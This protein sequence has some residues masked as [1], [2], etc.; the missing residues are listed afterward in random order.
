MHSQ[1][2]TFSKRTYHLIRFIMSLFVA[3]LYVLIIVSASVQAQ[4]D[5]PP[6][7]LQINEDGVEFTGN[8]LTR[9]LA[10]GDVDNDGDLDLAVANYQ[11]P[12]RVYFNEGGT[13]IDAFT[14]SSNDAD[15]TTS[16]AWGDVDNDGDLDLAVGNDGTTNKIYLNIDGQ[17]EVDSFW[18]TADADSTTSIVWGDIDG[19]DNLDLVSGNNG[20]V[21]RA[22]F[23]TG[24][25]LDSIAAWVSSEANSTS[26][27]SLGDID[28]D[29]NLDLAVGNLGSP[30][31]VY[32]GN[33]SSLESTP[34]WS[35]SESNWTSSIALG[36]MDNNG[37]LDFVAGNYDG[38][39][40]QTEEES[41][42]VYLNYSGQPETLSSWTTLSPAIG[43]VTTIA[44]GDADGDGDLDLA[45]ASDVRITQNSTELII[46][47]ND[48]E[49]L[50]FFEPNQGV[51]VHWASQV[52]W[53]DFDNDGD[54]DLAVVNAELP[55]LIF[56]NNGSQ[57]QTMSSW[58]SFDAFNPP[59]G[60]DNSVDTSIAWGDVDNDGDL[61]L[62][63]SRSGN[64]SDL[65]ASN[66]VYLNENGLLEQSP[67]WESDEMDHTSS[68]AWGDVDGDGDLDLAVGNYEDPNVGPS[69]NNRV[70]LNQG[71]QLETTASWSSQEQNNTNSIAWGDVDSDGDLD[72][73]VGNTSFNGAIT[74]NAVNKLYLNSGTQL[75]ATASWSSKEM[76][77]TNS[78]S[79]GDV[80]GDGD[81][82]LAVGNG[83]FELG[84]PFLTSENS[85][86]RLYINHRGELQTS[87]KW[88]T[89]EATD[90]TSI[91]WGDVDSDG[92]LDLLAEE[93]LYINVLG[94]L[95]L[96]TPPP[97]IS[98]DTGSGEIFWNNVIRGFKSWNDVD[99]DGDLDLATSSFLLRNSNGQLLSSIWSPS[100]LE[101]SSGGQPRWGDIDGD[102]DFDLVYSGSDITTPSRLYKNNYSNLNDHFINISALGALG[103]SPIVNG[104]GT[105]YV[106]ESGQLSVEYRVYDPH[107]R[108]IEEVRMFF[109]LD[110]GGQ[111]GEAAATAE[112]QV[113]NLITDPNQPMDYIYDWDIF[114]SGVFGQHDNVVVRLVARLDCINTCQRG[115]VA[116]SSFPFRVR[117]TQIRVLT[118]TNDPVGNVPVYLLPTT[119]IRNASPFASFS[120]ESYTTNSQGYLQ[121]R[122][123][124]NTGDKLVALHPVI[125]TENYT[126]YHTSAD[127]VVEGLNMDGVTQFGIQELI[128]SSD[129]PLVL[130]NLDVSLEW[131]ARRDLRYLEQLE[132]DI[133]RTSELLYDWSNGQAALGNVTVYHAKERWGD[134]DVRI[135]ANNRLRPHATIGGVVSGGLYHEVTVNGTTETL[136]YTPGHVE[137][138]ALWN[139]YGEA[140]DSLSEDWA[141]TLAHELGHYLF[142]LF[143]NYIGVQNNSI[144]RIEGCPG[145]MSD[146][147]SDV[148]SE[149]HPTT[150][151]TQNCNDTLSQQM[152][153]QS[154]WETILD[155]YP[156]LFAPSGS[157]DDAAESGPNTL[158]LAVTQIE[159]V[160]PAADPTTVDV[161]TIFLTLP[162]GSPYVA[163]SSA[164]AFLFHDDAMVDLGTPRR[165]R[166]RAWNASPGDTLCVY[167]LTNA[168]QVAG[169]DT[170]AQGDTEMMLA[171]LSTWQPDVVITPIDRSQIQVTVTNLAASL[172]LDA[173]LYPANML[174]GE[175]ALSPV[176]L[177]QQADGSYSA[178][179]TTD[180]LTQ[181]AYLRIYNT[182]N[183]NHVVVADYTIGGA[184]VLS[185]GSGDTLSLSSG[186]TLSLS[187][188]GTLQLTDGDVLSLS[189]GDVV[190]FMSDG[191][192]LTLSS[193]DTLTLS[194]GGTLT[195]S[196]GDTL[197]LSSGSTLS[198]SSGDIAI[199]SLDGTTLSLSSGDTLSLSSGDT[200]TLSSGDTLSLSS[201]DT[202]SLS[203]GDVIV[204]L[205][206][207]TTL[208]LSSGDTLSLS[209][210]ST[211]SLSSGGTLSLS[212]GD[213]LS[214]SSG[215]VVITELDG[216]T[217][218]LSSGDTLSLSSGGTLSL[219]SG[220]TLSLSSG[221]TLSLSSGD[222]FITRLDG[223]TLSLSSGDTLSLSS[224]GT[225]SLSSG[226][227]LS[228]SSG[229]TLSLSSGGVRL[230]G[231]GDVLSLSSGSAPVRSG[232]GQV[233]LY[234]DHR[235][236]APG[237][238]YTIQPATI[239][240]DALSW[241]TFIGQ[242]Y[243]ITA[244]PNAPDLTQASISINYLG[245]SID[246][247]RE[248]LL[249][250]YF[251]DGTTWAELETDVDEYHNRAVSA[252]Q[253]PGIYALM[254][255]IDI[256]LANTGWNLIAYPLDQPSPVPDVFASIDG[257]YSTVYGYDAFEIDQFQR[258][259]IYDTASPTWVNDLL[260]LTPGRGYWIN[261]N[262]NATLKLRDISAAAVAAAASTPSVPPATYYGRIV[263]QE[264]SDLS[265]G[266]NIQAWVGDVLCG[267]GQ[268]KEVDGQIVYV[269]T[270]YADGNGSIRGCGES[271]DTVH[272]TLDG[273]AL[274]ASNTVWN[275]ESVHEH[276]LTTGDD[277]LR[278]QYL[279]FVSQ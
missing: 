135:H 121:G 11:E 33:G 84:A 231:V 239:V 14:W 79:W 152:M 50:Q 82:D 272:F 193:G 101:F 104:Y 187:S 57:L 49:N 10:W 278:E 162:D 264:S 191:T 224:G 46:Y 15:P 138:G 59:P 194:S 274:P 28:S 180:Q 221:D 18:E 213:T 252:A 261:V 97:Y 89:G 169:C 67:I 115:S 226:D 131:D 29:G 245:R 232:D 188:G 236:F 195:L 250:V 268:T 4:G 214:L 279:P 73:A 242:A 210:G 87:A 109:S 269:V 62:A 60:E 22:Y 142:F 238:F 182:A 27:I 114:G 72:L 251:Y 47:Q 34:S 68:I 39:I 9:G 116:T 176:P 55:N 220:G 147:Y 154:D 88:S 37:S 94:E 174:A 228:L 20:E 66:R 263:T 78:V 237:E 19:D 40:D 12:N 271:G 126:L 54:I 70:Y 3:V 26:S 76:D 273:Q 90:T 7:P 86:D 227:T 17:L 98:D 52:G 200:L 260:E 172:S 21:N 102:G 168:T 255:T 157:I 45:T 246:D 35:T 136:L 163:G 149:F 249:H 56:K 95:H 42:K 25:L 111:W 106:E 129:N 186:D 107:G 100:S 276:D 219:S 207:G 155:F 196:S 262:A 223:T 240:P 132:F 8:D 164:R 253:G 217:L 16:V 123:A 81:L 167:E 204:M 243:R 177:T 30:N 44:L 99:N 2:K 137:M 120:S 93:H 189:S 85:P 275:S 205:A 265:A 170:I 181:E 201:G 143:D 212:S 145:V 266:M 206:D 69:A 108:N 277:N 117:G 151:W 1:N 130:Y 64:V 140:G 71:G 270:V 218:S 133:L 211:L 230:V 178:T 91:I 32:F 184:P 96:S 24:I 6:E 175:T 234:A 124:V 192:A 259:E 248:N 171:T 74:P 256:P 148:D 51:N 43:G 83:S 36:D 63:V 161:N 23:N 103:I 267:Q 258:W 183:P 198:L 65:G 31:K 254:Y 13:F 173:R 190:I 119:Q 222:T 208:S 127:P 118:E 110:G 216:E 41:T 233:T 159:Y 244:S 112:T 77:N 125:E 257:V 146:P 113:T 153:G 158:P 203:S 179:L 241:T 185:L 235:D 197:S 144:T 48:I 160:E 5:P 202:L 75:E 105:A 199:T 139:R 38:S 58:S 229:G 156:W 122:G 247:D 92:D 215:D 80:D 209:S 150:G 225:L 134:A 165:D 61:D 141:R 166:V 53:G 128:I